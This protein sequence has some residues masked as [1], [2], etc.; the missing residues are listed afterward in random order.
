MK[1]KLKTLAKVSKQ[2]S[3][4]QRWPI[5]FRG[6]TAT[7]TND[8]TE[9]TLRLP[10]VWI[11][12][13]EAKL[14]AV[15][16]L[17]IAARLDDAD[18]LRIE[19]SDDYATVNGVRVMIDGMQ[20]GSVTPNDE[21]RVELEVTDEL[22]EAVEAVR[23]CV[24]DDPL[25]P[26]MNGVYIDATMVAATDAHVLAWRDVATGLP[27]GVKAVFIRTCG[28]LFRRNMMA[29]WCWTVVRFGTL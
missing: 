8:T 23:A 24:A 28:P 14:D 18:E 21:P 25:R 12:G 17:K 20:A 16:V 1:N 7:A 22:R 19:V 5:V 27:D 3:R 11:S 9:L 29:R 2:R 10:I 6:C 13:E 26:V 15:A 4:S